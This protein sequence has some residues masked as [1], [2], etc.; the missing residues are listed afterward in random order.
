MCQFVICWEF[1]Q[2]DSFLIVSHCGDYKKCLVLLCICWLFPFFVYGWIESFGACLQRYEWRN[3]GKVAVRDN[4]WEMS[5]LLVGTTSTVFFPLY[6]K[7][8][9]PWRHENVYVLVGGC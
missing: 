4:G 2:L 7:A 6:F 3:A 9:V 8:Y 5:V 1:S